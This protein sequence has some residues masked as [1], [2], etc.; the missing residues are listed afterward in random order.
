MRCH[1]CGA[2]I[3]DDSVF[4]NY[5]GEKVIVRVPKK[6]NN[7][8]QEH[9]VR[10]RDEDFEQ[11]ES[12]KKEEET[13]RT[14][15]QKQLPWVIA[16]IILAGAIF[17]VLSILL[18]Q[19][20]KK[21]QRTVVA[22]QSSSAS[23]S[24]AV[25]TEPQSSESETAAGTPEES[26]EAPASETP[27]PEESAAS[28]ETPAAPEET[29]AET[30]APSSEETAAPVAAGMEVEYGGIIYELYEDHA[31]LKKC[32]SEDANVEL[33]NN[34]N[35]VPLTAIGEA[36]FAD[37]NH[38][39]KVDIPEGVKDLGPYAFTWCKNLQQVVFPDSLETFG[40]HCLDGAGAITF[41]AHEGTIGYQTAVNN[42]FPYIIGD[43]IQ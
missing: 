38:L 23:E 25:M 36:A 20:F 31:V 10:P 9:A 41:I 18:Y 37:C 16:M 22:A 4:C 17:A 3:R 43:S 24:P 6:E 32:Y 12:Q 33:P 11:P 21:N 26:T 39:Q 7:T 40:D 19:G 15:P 5:C 28:E 35:G 27:A 29:P 34:I 42:N 30:P 13:E 2:Y 8:E 14:V 1:K